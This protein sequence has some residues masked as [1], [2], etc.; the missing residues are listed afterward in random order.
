M[1]SCFSAVK[2]PSTQPFRAAAAGFFN[3]RPRGKGLF[4]VFD[5][6]RAAAQGA[7]VRSCF[8]FSFEKMKKSCGVFV[9]PAP[10]SEK[11]LFAH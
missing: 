1:R 10:G 6:K 3:L 2:Q 4:L 9:F 11:G 5:A 8:S 7:F